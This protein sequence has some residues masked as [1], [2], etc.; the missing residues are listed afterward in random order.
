MA[1]TMSQISFQRSPSGM[2]VG[3]AGAWLSKENDPFI[4]VENARLSSP[5]ACS[6]M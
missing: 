2:A 6:P 5:L 1:R 4:S 3:G